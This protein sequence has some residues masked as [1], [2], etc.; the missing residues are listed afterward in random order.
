[1]P[2]G[3]G[4][5]EPAFTANDE[6]SIKAYVEKLGIESKWDLFAAFAEGTPI[7]ALRSSDEVLA[8]LVAMAMGALTDVFDRAQAIGFPLF[9]ED[10]EI[11][12]AHDT[13]AEDRIAAIER[14]DARMR[15][16]YEAR[17]QGA[18]EAE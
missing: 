10:Y 3:H 8:D 15:A 1:M 11:A 12:L 17:M 14:Y 16:D 6:A 2:K 7:G 5:P 4:F 9:D 18:E 13:S